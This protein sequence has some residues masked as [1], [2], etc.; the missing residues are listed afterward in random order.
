MFA[1][2]HLIAKRANEIREKP[3][4]SKEW[5]HGSRRLRYSMID[6]LRE[7]KRLIGK[8]PKEV[9]QLLGTPDSKSQEDGEL[10]Y[11]LDCPVMYFTY[12]WQYFFRIYFDRTSPHVVRTE[13][14]D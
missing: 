1:S 10:C 14:W 4:V 6:D 12:D 2:I 3:F 9:E 5:K 8:S 7:S 13:L 11:V